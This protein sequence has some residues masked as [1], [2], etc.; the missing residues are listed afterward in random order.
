VDEQRYR[1]A[2]RALWESVGARPTERLVHL[3]GCDA[4]VRIQEMGDGAPVVFLHGASN[5]GTSWASLAARLDTFRCV[6]V[7]RPGC[8]LSPRL[9]HPPTDTAE[10]DA[11]ADGFVVDLLDAIGVEEAHV[12]ATS[13]GGYFALR[14]AAAH[15]DRISRLVV[16]GWTFGAPAVATPL[17]MRIAT[18]PALQR[19]ATRVPVNERMARSML[20]QIGLRR[21]IESGTFGPVEMAWFL[22]LLRDTDT[23]RNEIDAAPRL[24][25]MSGFDEATLL[26]PDLLAQVV[27]PSAFLWGDEDPMGGEDTARPFVE[28]LPNAQLE[29]MDRAGHAP[30]IDDAEF[31]ARRVCGFLEPG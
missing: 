19:L 3:D 7:D 17:V 24:M 22:S 1:R 23:M 20:K 28:Q 9:E 15:P 27:A 16:L 30:W 5:G 13:F 4:H 14:S 18:H 12:I 26:P 6:L 29:L 31:V 11:F 25:T 2:E 21:A 8:G 10:F